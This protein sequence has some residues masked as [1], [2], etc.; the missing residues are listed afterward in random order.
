M[1]ITAQG[2]FDKDNQYD[3]IPMTI[4]VNNNN[5]RKTIY[6]SIDKNYPKVD[7]NIT[8]EFLLMCKT[9]LN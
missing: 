4:D 6:Q 3:V 9:N 8:D 1:I 5:S 7:K 2:K